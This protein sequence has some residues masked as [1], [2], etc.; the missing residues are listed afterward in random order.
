MCDE[1]AEQFRHKRQREHDFERATNYAHSEFQ[2]EYGCDPN[3]E[4][5]DDKEILVDLSMGNLSDDYGREEVEEF[6]GFEEE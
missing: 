6:L 4:D 1:H 5:L 2:R 3:K